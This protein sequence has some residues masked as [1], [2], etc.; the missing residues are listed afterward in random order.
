M[1]IIDISI[2]MDILYMKLA[3]L[4]LVAVLAVSGVSFAS[5]AQLSWDA[6]TLDTAFE[7]KFTF[8]R[9]ITID[10]SDGG[11]IANDLR[12]KQESVQHHLDGASLSP[13]IES[14][15]KKLDQSGSPTRISDLVLDYSAT[16]TGYDSHASIEYNVILVP[17]IDQFLLY[18]SSDTPVLFDVSWRGLVIDEPIIIEG[19][20]ITKPISLVEDKFP[21]VVEQIKG[22]NADSLFS[23]TIID[24]S[25]IKEQNI[26]SWHSLFDPTGIIPGAKSYGF[27]EPIITTFSM[28]TSDIF[29]PV[30]DKIQKTA[31]MLDEK[32]VISTFEAADSANMMIPGYAQAGSIDIHEIIRTGP[33]PTSGMPP[34]DDQERF[35]IFVMYGMAGIAAAGA[36]GFFWWSSKRAKKES[37]LG[38]TGIDPSQLRGIE[39]SS[40][41]GGYKTNRGEAQLIG[42]ADYSQTKNLYDKPRGTLPK[43]WTR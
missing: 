6:R 38:Q 22:S 7:P 4:A 10:Y 19:Y 13:I 36:G 18:E 32:Y 30:G 9:T 41:S 26:A 14:L 11:I 28:G 12:G 31:L 3:I 25:K 8:Q 5:A 23:H 29:N 20:D 16:L 27:D 2:F 21:L 40:A 33:N 15:N 42:E 1:I 24:A 17:K 37:S 34:G 43:G 35:P 39:T